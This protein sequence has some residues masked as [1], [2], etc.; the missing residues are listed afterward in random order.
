MK[1]FNDIS[2]TKNNVNSKPLVMLIDDMVRSY[3][4]DGSIYWNDQNWRLGLESI[5]DEHMEL[6]A[7]D[8]KNIDK[9]KVVCNL[10]NNPDESVSNNIYRLDVYYQQLNCLNTTH[11]SYKIHWY[12]ISREVSPYN[13]GYEW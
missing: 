13:Y 7:A 2:V 8:T 10:Q 12:I 1:V 11:L 5:I 6:I 4:D 3:I 9:W